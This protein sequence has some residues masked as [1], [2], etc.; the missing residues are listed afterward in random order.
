MERKEIN[1]IFISHNS[2]LTRPIFAYKLTTS[3]LTSTER[4]HTAK[5]A[6]DEISNDRLIIY[7][8]VN[9]SFRDRPINKFVMTCNFSCELCFFA[10]HHLC[11]EKKLFNGITTCTTQAATFLSLFLLCSVYHCII[12]EINV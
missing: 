9:F 11:N 4:P 6:S 5:T 1:R 8:N 2:K 12:V 10:A 3:C 7:K